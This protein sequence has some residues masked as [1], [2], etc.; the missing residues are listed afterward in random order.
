MSLSLLAFP[1]N[2]VHC[3]EDDHWIPPQIKD[4]QMVRRLEVFSH[5]GL[6]YGTEENPALRI[7]LKAFQFRPVVFGEVFYFVFI[8]VKLGADDQRGII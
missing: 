1:N 5:T 2:T 3:L 8:A 4:D 6:L 7:I